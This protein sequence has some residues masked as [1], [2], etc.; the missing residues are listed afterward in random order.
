MN[1]VGLR[2][3]ATRGFLPRPSSRSWLSQAA[4]RRS[5]R[6][7][8][9]CGR[10]RNPRVARRRRPTRFNSPTQRDP[11]YAAPC[12]A[13]SHEAPLIGCLIPMSR[14]PDR[15]RSAPAAGH[16]PPAGPTTAQWGRPARGARAQGEGTGATGSRITPHGWAPA[17]GTERPPLRERRGGDGSGRPHMC[18]RPNV[19]R[20]GHSHAC[21]RPKADRSWHSH[22][23]ESAEADRFW[24]SHV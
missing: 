21:E 22:V 7:H 10:G 11:A 1:R 16:S 8:S 17:S 5:S 3:L 13:S 14:S 20:S 24:S 12:T 6:G 19:D 15:G 23:C 2:R 4:P 9:D 18:E